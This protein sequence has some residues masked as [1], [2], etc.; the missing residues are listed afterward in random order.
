LKENNFD[1]LERMT[2][3]IDAN[4]IGTP[5]IGKGWGSILVRPCHIILFDVT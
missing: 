3:D 1:Q 4:W 5:P 2:K